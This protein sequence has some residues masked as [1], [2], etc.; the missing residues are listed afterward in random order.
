M[1]DT[2][3]NTLMKSHTQNIFE[4]S[5]NQNAQQT[6]NLKDKLLASS[7]KPSNNTMIK[8]NTN[9]L[10]NSSHNSQANNSDS[11]KPKSFAETTAHQNSPKMNQAIVLPIINDI[12]QLEYLTAIS[13]FTSPL[14]IIAASRISNDR[15]CVFLNSQ[16][17]ADELVKNHPNIIIN[18][19]TI[20]IRK[21]INPSK[22]IILSNVY[23]IIPDQVIF[24][25]LH[26]IKIRTTSQITHLKS[27]LSTDQFSHITSFRR[28]LYINP[29]DFPHLPSSITVTQENTTFRIYLSDDTPTCFTCKLKG[30]ISSSCKNNP[31]N[32]ENDINESVPDL[33]NTYH[34]E[35][36]NENKN[37][38]N[39]NT[40]N[41][42]T[43][44]QNKLSSNI[45]K[46]TLDQNKRS[47]SNSSTPFTSPTTQSH[48]SRSQTDKSFESEDTITISSTIKKKNKKPK[49]RSRSN[50]S[51]NNKNNESIDTQLEPCSYLF[52][53]PTK[54][55]INFNLFKYIVENSSNKKVN[56][57]DL[58]NQ[59]GTDIESLHKTIEIIRPHLKD[60]RIKIKMTKLSNLLF[61][62]MPPTE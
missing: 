60:Q 10:T 3:P 13:K 40:V 9:Q 5:K 11:S 43:K 20:P 26:E 14:N 19:N 6:I 2:P 4:Q 42:H 38:N 55:P 51:S 17:T 1:G 45:D 37:T 27:N 39:E 30:H 23:P 35:N 58:C 29:E 47:L 7:L 48:Q 49:I 59:F 15:F 24:K 62:I 44:E 33:N 54:I 57:K 28:Q 61:Q 46:T 12:K 56:L 22:K 31:T 8:T 41:N 52:E 25:A 36:S 18:D 16:N 53:H 50:S 32:I 21:L 34:E